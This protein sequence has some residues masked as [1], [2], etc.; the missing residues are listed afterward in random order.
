M[1]SQ[2]DETAEDIKNQNELIKE[3]EYQRFERINECIER[4]RENMVYHNAQKSSL[5]DISN[6]INDLL[7]LRNERKYAFKD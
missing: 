1:V 6:K 3:Q 4:Q 2:R 7:M 5:N